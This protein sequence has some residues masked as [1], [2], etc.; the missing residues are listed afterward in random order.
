MRN[1]GVL[2]SA[3]RAFRLGA[4]D[5]SDPFTLSNRVTMSGEIRPGQTFTF[6][7][8][9]TAP[10][11][12]TYVTDW[13]MVRD[14]YEWFGPVVSKTVQVTGQG[15]FQPPTQPQA[16]T[17]TVLGP[18]SIRLNWQPSTDNVGVV[19]YDVRRNSAIVASPASNTHTDTPEPESGYT[20]PGAPR[21][22]AGNVSSWS[23]FA[24]AF[25]QADSEAP[26]VPANVVAVGT[27]PGV[28]Q[29]T[30][31]A[32][33]VNVGV[34]SY[35]IRRDGSVMLASPQPHSPSPTGPGAGLCV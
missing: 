14:G 29:I 6:N 35:D 11:Q 13:R 22:E 31:A 33:T 19:G 18:T 2:W 27:A 24:T 16:L 5:D 4:V 26:S 21:D 30:W 1:R 3:I 7:F 17:A 23:D 8:Q 15:D 10:A 9:M 12:G 32:S 28:V 25:T 20:Y 34:T